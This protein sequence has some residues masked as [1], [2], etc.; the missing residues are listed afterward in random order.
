MYKAGSEETVF[1]KLLCFILIIIA[2]DSLTRCDFGFIRFCLE[3]C[4]LTPTGFRGSIPVSRPVCV[5][6][7][8]WSSVVPSGVS[9]FLPQSKDRCDWRLQIF[10]T[11]SMSVNLFPE[12]PAID[13]RF[14]TTENVW[15]DGWIEVLSPNT[16]IN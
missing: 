10:S 16:Q 11:L 12:S 6:V 15:M 8:V 9:G 14:H 5:C 2:F 3:F 4:C 1:R 7:C 13:S